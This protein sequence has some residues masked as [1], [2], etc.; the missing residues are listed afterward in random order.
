MEI[1]SVILFFLYTWGFGFALCRFVQESDNALEK[2]LMR[3]GIGLGA[4]LFFGFVLNLLHIPLDWRI[5]LLFVV[6]ALALHFF[7][8]YKNIHH[9]GFGIRFS[10]SNVSILIMLL[11]FSA[12]FYMYHKG[13]FAYPYLED[14][15]SWSHAIS[16]KYVSIEKT[17][18][19]TTSVGFHYMDPYPPA[20]GM[21]FGVL[22]QTNG[23]VH[24]T[25]KFFNALIISLSIIF[26]YFFIK[27]FTGNAAKSL[28]STFALA[29][30]PAYL[31]HFIW[32]LALT[33][34]LYF[35][36]FYCLERIRH[37]KKWAFVA[38]PVVMVTLT[39]SPT[40]STY[41]GLFFILYLLTKMALERRV[42]FYH[43]LAGILGLVLSFLLWWLPMI[44]KY[45]L[46]GTLRGIG[47]RSG[48]GESIISVT[49]TAD[50][51]Y[52]ISD[53]VWAKA[54]NM[55]NSPTGIGLVLS[56]LVVL[57]IIAII[58]NYKSLLKEENHWIVISLALF[59]FALYAVNAAKMPV[60]L[61]PF[62]AWM[63]LAIPTAILASYGLWF[64]ISL[65]KNLSIPK[66]LV[67]A[68]IVIGVIFTS[69][70][71]KYA[72]NTAIWPP[73][74]FWTSNDE[75]KGY[76]WLK[77]NLPRETKVFTFSNDGIVIGMDKFICSWCDE[78]VQFKKNGFNVTAE[79]TYS[80]LKSNG[81]GYIL[82]DGQ[83]AQRFGSNAT[84]SKL[85]QLL[86]SGRFAPVHQTAG[87]VLLRT[88]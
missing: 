66:S 4:F 53:F 40:H 25:L 65:L 70:Y 33:V 75:I 74:G 73:G 10:K 18:F 7:R 26:F 30:V 55:I 76:I 84:N 29:S 35:V 23:S 28:F 41:F 8:N 9:M 61:S 19:K 48:G 42:L 1:L 46:V 54:T 39:S 32:A 49:G 87:L 31:S 38:A 34:P 72:L 56:L 85:Q 6:L 52:S 36:S 68:V 88:A 21:L 27:E 43:A 16:V 67:V 51:V 86:A 57:S 80:W 3:I 59:V 44:L 77:D 69:A 50:R 58:L 71:Q 64:L 17:V 83:T 5:F 45:G 47:L 11:I 79:Q 62:R 13:A 37:D 2:N 24:W 15:D 82:I 63:L 81:Y 12:T 20:Y 14:D 22:H 78:I 60:K